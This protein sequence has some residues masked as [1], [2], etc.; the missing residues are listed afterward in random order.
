MPVSNPASSLIDHDEETVEDA[1]IK[2]NEAAVV[3]KDV[4]SLA[5]DVSQ[6]PAD[7][8]EE[9]TNQSEEDAPLKIL[10]N[11]MTAPQPLERH[12]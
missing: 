10:E 1:N 12:G 8:Q 3:E 7:A 4:T 5:D 9:W 11:S 6:A 2:I